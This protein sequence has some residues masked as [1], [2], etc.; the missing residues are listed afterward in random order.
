ADPNFIPADGRG[1]NP[2]LQSPWLVIHPPI[3]FLGFS[4]MSVPFCFAMAALWRR[5]F[6]EWIKPA[7][8]WTLGANLC[9]LVA[10]FLGAYWAY[11]TLSF[12]G[13]WAWDPV[14]NAALVPWLLGMA[15]IHVMIVQKK[16]G[17]TQKS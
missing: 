9:L 12:G 14:E 11:V 15:G 7:L 8:P 3:F 5:K 1:L 17:T 4:L 16:N 6:S 13:F 10:L 2:L